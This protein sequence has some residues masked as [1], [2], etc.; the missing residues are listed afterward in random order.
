MKL[1]P[2]LIIFFF[3][4]SCRQYTTVYS[5][6][7]R[8]NVDDVCEVEILMWERGSKSYSDYKSYKLSA[9]N[10]DKNGLQKFIYM[11]KTVPNCNYTANVQSDTV[12]FSIRIY[13]N[14]YPTHFLVVADSKRQTGTGNIYF[15]SRKN[16]PFGLG[17]VY[18][19]K[20]F[21]YTNTLVYCAEYVKPIAQFA[22][23]CIKRYNKVNNQNLD[24][25]PILDRY[26]VE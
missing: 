11:I 1:I 4:S 8:V 26:I 23:H 14:Y 17:W 5:E 25:I 19:Q 22:N 10:I 12:D 20:N 16:D 2:I 18:H 9:D 13:F 15:E 24:T 7:Q 3:F 21:S 6:L